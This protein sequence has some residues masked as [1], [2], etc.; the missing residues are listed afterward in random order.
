MD[1]NTL[2]K[3]LEELNQPNPWEER[4]QKAGQGIE[5]IGGFLGGILAIAVL[6]VLFG[7]GIQTRNLFYGIVAAVGSG[8]SAYLVYRIMVG[9]GAELCALAEQLRNDRITRQIMLQMLELQKQSAAAASVQPAQLRA[10]DSQLQEEGA[11]LTAELLALESAAET[12]PE[13][14]E[15]EQLQARLARIDRELEKL[16]VMEF[17]RAAALKRRKK[18][19]EAGIAALDSAQ[20][21]T[22]ERKAA[23]ENR[24]DQIHA[25][26][27]TIARLLEQ[28]EPKK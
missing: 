28:I 21:S 6:F 12:S 15:K 16:G 4:L 17:Q 22:A 23:L 26:R 10:E 2:E 20:S 13:A 9:R 18:E 27:K 8:L 19:Y 24:L 3:K 11:A 1:Q 14:Q 5:T 25:R 7:V